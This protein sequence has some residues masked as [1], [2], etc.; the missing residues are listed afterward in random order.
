VKPLKT[1]DNELAD[2]GR[3]VVGLSIAK[4]LISDN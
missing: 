4:F 1:S 2:G 3:K